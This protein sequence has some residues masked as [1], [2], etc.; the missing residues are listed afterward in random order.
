MKHFLKRA[1]AAAVSLALLAG[2]IPMAGADIL[3]LPTGKRDTVC[4][5]VKRLWTTDGSFYRKARNYRNFQK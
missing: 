5:W 3:L 1:A 2:M 4:A